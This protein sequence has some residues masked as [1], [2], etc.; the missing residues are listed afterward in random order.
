MLVTGEI[1]HPELFLPIDHAASPGKPCNRI[2]EHGDD[3]AS[4]IVP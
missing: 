1:D 4:Y 3:I 2:P